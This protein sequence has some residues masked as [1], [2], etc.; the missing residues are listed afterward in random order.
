MKDFYIPDEFLNSDFYKSCSKHSQHLVRVLFNKLMNADIE[1]LV[2][3]E[4][5]T[6]LLWLYQAE[7]VL[8]KTKML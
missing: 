7:L 5:V 1:F 6:I 3:K 8:K 4:Q 2:K